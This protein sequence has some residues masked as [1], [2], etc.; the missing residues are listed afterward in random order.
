[1]SMT[2]GPMKMKGV[3]YVTFDAGQKKWTRFAV[4]S[5]GGHEIGTSMDGK[6]W[7][8]E[9]SMMGMTMKVKTNLETSAKEFKVA[10][11]MSMDG[12]KW[13][14]GFEMACKK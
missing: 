6:K 13:F 10:S 11:E 12:K 3:E 14:K 7:E 1:M 5:M 4:D 8:G 9:M 2:A